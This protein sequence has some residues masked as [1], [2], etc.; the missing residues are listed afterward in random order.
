MESKQSSFTEDKKKIDNLRNIVE[1]VTGERILSVTRYRG[2]VEARMIFASLLKDT[3]M[4]V[5]S[6]AYNM[7]K[8]R[9]SAEYYLK[10]LNELL[11]VDSNFRRLYL[12]CK[13]MVVMNKFRD[14][15]VNSY[16][17]VGRLVQENEALKKEL[18]LLKEKMKP[19]YNFITEK[20]WM[21]ESNKKETGQLG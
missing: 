12:K 13:E 19:V 18:R 10:R 14:E 17:I 15:T 2:E 5:E 8:S 9:Y 1:M 7:K 11:E 20:E 16:N 3:G 4:H 6:I 21:I